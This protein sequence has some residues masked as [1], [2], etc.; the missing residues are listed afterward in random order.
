MYVTC[1]GNFDGVHIGH[2]QIMNETIKLASKSKIFSKALTI[3]YPWGYFFENFPGLIYHISERIELIQSTGIKEVQILDLKEIKD[4]SPD[5]FFELLLENDVKGIVVGDDFTFGRK[6][7][8]D[9][10]TL[11]R[12]SKKH[13][14]ELKVIKGVKYRE[15]RVSSSWIRE[16]ISRGEIELS[17]TLLGEHY[18][19][20][21]K[22]YKDKKLGN[23]LGFPTAN[24]ER[25]KANLVHPKPGV[26]VVSSYIDEV[27][28]FGLMNAGFR[29]TINYSEKMKYEVYFLDFS[30]SLY[31]K[32]L[33]IKFH[34]FLRP[35][36]KFDSVDKLVKEI[37][38]DEKIARRW[39]KSNKDMIKDGQ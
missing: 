38:R 26:Y 29:P 25:G 16:T 35:E 11:E 30:G 20:N 27:Q 7:A 36:L 21:G 37:Q 3:N 6:A 10:N 33:S 14:V 23:I 18:A 28:Y 12:L 22:A 9:V 4:H 24:I 8:G 5:E 19:I 2:R 39:I 17:N 31:D 34:K 15:K 1:I 32:D 13:S